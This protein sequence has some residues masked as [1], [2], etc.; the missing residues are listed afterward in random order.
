MKIIKKDDAGER[1]YEILAASTQS[2]KNI[3]V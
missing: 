2:P 3:D 1:S